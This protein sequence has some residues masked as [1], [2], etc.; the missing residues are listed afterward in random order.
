MTFGGTPV[1]TVMWHKI[2]V[3]KQTA[4]IFLTRPTTVSGT[5]TVNNTLGIM[6]KS[7]KMLKVTANVTQVALH[8]HD[9]YINILKMLTETMQV[10]IAYQESEMRSLY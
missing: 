8:K 5:N 10:I 1:S 2:Q 6:F 9:K 4:T 3:C 7:V